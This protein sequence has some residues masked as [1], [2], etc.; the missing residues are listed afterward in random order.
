MNNLWEKRK[1]VSDDDTCVQVQRETER[2]TEINIKREVTYL[3]KVHQP[4]D[5]SQ[6]YLI[7][8]QRSTNECGRF[9]GHAGIEF[10]Y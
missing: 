4:E 5:Q 1:S 2:Q 8:Q 6:R 10:R 9:K 7:L 3:E